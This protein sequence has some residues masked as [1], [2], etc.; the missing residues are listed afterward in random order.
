MAQALMRSVSNSSF[1][2]YALSNSPPT[3]PAPVYFHGSQQSHPDLLN[4]AR[5]FSPSPLPTIRPL[6]P[7]PSTKYPVHEDDPVFFPH[8]PPAVD[9]HEYSP[10]DYSPLGVSSSG[11]STQTTDA[12]WR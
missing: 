7:T 5:G 11:S 1:D 4:R 12:R 8:V 9:P 3:S 10:H 6:P 2:A